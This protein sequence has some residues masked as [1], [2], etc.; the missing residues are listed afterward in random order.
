MAAWFVGCIPSAAA[1]CPP[2][3]PLP[4]ARRSPRQRPRCGSSHRRRSQASTIAKELLSGQHVT[5]VR[6]EQIEISGSFIRN[7]RASQPAV[8][9]AH[10]PRAARAAGGQAPPPRRAARFRRQQCAGH[11]RGQG[12]TVLLRG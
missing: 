5:V 11:K 8:T 6:C 10:A 4:P 2:D 1:A 12:S 7:K 3:A 9:I